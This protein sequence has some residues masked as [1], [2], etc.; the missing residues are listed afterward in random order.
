MCLHIVKVNSSTFFEYVTGPSDITG[1]LTGQML[2]HDCISAIL[3]LL[4]D[5]KVDCQCRA[6]NALPPMARFG[7]STSLL[8]KSLLL[9]V[10]ID[11]LRDC[12]V[13]DRTLRILLEKCR[14]T[15]P[16]VHNC[17]ARALSLLL[18]HRK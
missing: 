6:L 9:N 3:D 12:I 18:D 4:Q 10:F 13:T 8:P 2:S 11:P 14:N 15:N 1:L 17:S 5:D 16:Q 7:Q